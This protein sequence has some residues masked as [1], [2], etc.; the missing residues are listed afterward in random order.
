MRLGRSG[1]R[2]LR[3]RRPL[4][5][6][7]EPCNPGNQLFRY[8][9]AEHVRAR[10]PGS[11]ITGYQL[12]DFGLES[13]GAAPSGRLLRTRRKH[14]L[15]VSAL[16]RDAD[17]GG[18]D[19]LLIDCY[20]QRLEYFEDRRDQFAQLFNPSTQGHRTTADELV[21]NVRAGEILTG[22]HPDYMPLPVSF[23]RRLVRE[24][25]LAP[26]FVGQVDDDA[27]GAAIRAA[28]PDAR[29]IAS[30]HWIEDFQTVRNATN[31]VIGV[32]SFSWLAAWLS[33]TARTIHLPVAGFLNPNQ[34][35]DIDLLPK[36]D[37]RYVFHPFD[38]EKFAATPEQMARILD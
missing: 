38:P 13:D 15:D 17:E 33:T 18:Y 32:S 25:G 14:Q 2:T 19:G 29:Y 30:K 3:R 26:A 1:R 28:F 12:P 21:I 27:Y 10:R 22:L 11:G 35:P 7:V 8:M 34:R 37:D 20:A 23:Y 24:T 31:I 16:L 4:V 5:L 6:H 9:F 36:D